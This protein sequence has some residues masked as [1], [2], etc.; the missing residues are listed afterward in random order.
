M[1]HQPPTVRTVTLRDRP[2]ILTVGEPVLVHPDGTQVDDEE[3][4]TYTVTHPAR[5]AHDPEDGPCLLAYE[6]EAV[7]LLWALG[8]VRNSTTVEHLPPGEYLIQP[9]G[10]RY[11]VPGEAEEWD[12]GVHVFDHVPFP[13]PTPETLPDGP[14]DPEPVTVPPNPW[15]DLL[16]AF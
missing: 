2:H 10:Q 8:V 5:C 1:S 16:E 12:S 7:G 4:V 13:R 6:I 15:V 11:S 9:W 3:Q 14:F